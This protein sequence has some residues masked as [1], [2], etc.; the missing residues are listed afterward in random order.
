MWPPKDKKKGDKKDKKRDRSDS[1][2]ED[3]GPVPEIGAA[4]RDPAPRNHVFKL[5]Q[6]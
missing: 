3:L 2:Q 1:D 5:S 6:Q 4:Q